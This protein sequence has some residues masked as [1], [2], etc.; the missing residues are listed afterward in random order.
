MTDSDQTQAAVLE[1][2]RAEIAED[3]ETALSLRI[4]QSL[5]RTLKHR[6]AAEGLPVSA[7]V[8]RLLTRAV[9]QPDTPWSPSNRSNRSPAAPPGTRSS[10]FAEPPEFTVRYIIWHGPI[11]APRRPDQDAWGRP[12]SGGGVYDPNDA[13][14]GHFVHEH[15][16]AEPA[17]LSCRGCVRRTR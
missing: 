6:A 2:L 9:E 13:T 3:K 14:G 10:T 5:S 8:R 16:S 4:P 7:L 17:A 1:A 11:W 12:Y 15:P